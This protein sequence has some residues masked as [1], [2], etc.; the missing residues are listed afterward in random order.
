LRESQTGGEQR[1]VENQRET[2][3]QDGTQQAAGDVEAAVKACDVGVLFRVAVGPQHHDQ[4]LHIAGN[5]RGHSR[6][7]YAHF[8][9][10]KMAE[11]Q[12][13]VA[14]QV[15]HRCDDACHHRYGGMAALSQ[16][17]CVGVGDGEG[18]QTQNHNVQVLPAVKQGVGRQ[19]GVTLASQVQTYQRIAAKEENGSGCAG[20]QDAAEQLKAEGVADALLVA[21]A[22]ELG[23]KDTG[24]GGAAEHAEVK[25]E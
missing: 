9:R 2:L 13:V 20:E 16:R 17:A 3:N 8:G 18:D 24:A 12:N 23:G 10:A 19:L 4:K 6:A 25:D 11:D 7:G 15:H 1:F 5:H 21:G 22:V 14:H